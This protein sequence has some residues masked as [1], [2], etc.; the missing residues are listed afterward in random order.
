MK[1]L[2][3]PFFDLRKQYY[4]LKNNISNS[5]SKACNDSAFVDGLYF[6][7]FEKQFS[8]YCSVNHAIELNKWYFSITFIFINIGYRQSR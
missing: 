3:I 2:K 6:Q 7:K 1:S 8:D 4:L 5:V